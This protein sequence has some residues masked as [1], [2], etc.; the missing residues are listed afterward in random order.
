MDEA[1]PAMGCTKCETVSL[2][3]ETET[4]LITDKY[5]IEFL[6]STLINNIFEQNL[7]ENLGKI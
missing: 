6:S 4:V 1:T 5:T 2:I 7:L 3:I